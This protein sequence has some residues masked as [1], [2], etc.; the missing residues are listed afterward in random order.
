VSYPC[1]YLPVVDRLLHPGRHWNC[2]NVPSF[3]DEV[4]DGQWSSRR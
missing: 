3:S 4:N 1:H 2:A